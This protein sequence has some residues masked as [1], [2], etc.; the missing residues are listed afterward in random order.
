MKPVTPYILAINGGSS[1]I[2]FALYSAEGSYKQLLVGELGS[3]GTHKPTFTYFDLSTNEKQ[4]T[5]IQSAN[6]NEAINFLISWLEKRSAFAFIKAIGHRIVQGMQLTEPKLVSPEILLALT[7]M[8]AYDPEHLPEEIELIHVFAKRHPTLPQVVCF[9]T[10]FH[11]SMPKIARLLSIPRTYFDKG[12]HRYGFHGLS[13]TYLMEELRRVAGREAALGK[14][15]LLHLGSGASLAAVQDGKCL[16]TSMGF[17]PASGLPMS[18]RCGDLDPGVAGYLIQAEKLSPIQFSALINHQSGL[19]GLS[20]TSAD[21]RE[22]LI[23]LVTDTR[24]KEAVDFFCYQTKKWIG[25]YAAALGGIDTLIFSG[26]IG[27]HAAEIRSQI[28]NGLAFLGIELDATRN[29]NHQ[30]IISKQTAK[31]F[32]RVMQTNE[33]II[34]ARSVCQVLNFI[35]KN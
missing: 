17:T 3:I 15:I 28:C 11:A 31:V 27:A 12:I 34:I 1:S 10:S 2:K 4:S 5:S 26:G 16:D 21:M 20:E 13:Y 9:D 35:S 25:A 7:R 30:A 18:T 32:V 14:I 29:E 8:S 22:L 23:A 33:E 19:L 24:A 6:H